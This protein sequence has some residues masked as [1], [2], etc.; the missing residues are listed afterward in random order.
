M[1]PSIFKAQL[2]NVAYHEVLEKKREEIIWYVVCTMMRRDGPTVYYFVM[3]LASNK[4]SVEKT[5]LVSR[6]IMY[7]C[8]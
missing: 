2:S 8:T 1:C 3:K 4:Y 7:L 5:I 6:C